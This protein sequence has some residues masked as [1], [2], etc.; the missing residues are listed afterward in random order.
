MPGFI[1]R[2]FGKDS[3]KSCH[4]LGTGPDLWNKGSPDPWYYHSKSSGGG[5]KKWWSRSLPAHIGV[6]LICYLAVYYFIHIIYKFAL[7]DEH[8]E[9]DEEESHVETERKSWS[10]KEEFERIVHFFD[11]NVSPLSKDLTF[12]LGFYVSQIVR[13]WWDQF[14][15]LPNPD[16]LVLL[17]HGLVDFTK[18]ANMVW[19]KRMMR[20]VLLAYV[21]CLRRISKAIRRQFPDYK[22][23][24]TCKLITRK[25]LMQIESQGDPGRVWWIPLS[26]VMTMIRSSKEDKVIAS[27]QKILIDAVSKFQ[28][29]LER[30]DDHDH[31]IL[32]PLYRQVV[33]FAVYIYFGLSLIGNQELDKDPYTFI[34]IFLI[35]KFIFFFGWLEVAEAIASPFGNDDDDFQVCELLSRHVWAV[36]RNL[37]QFRGPPEEE[38]EEE[39]E[40]KHV[41]T[42]SMDLHKNT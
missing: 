10:Q 12:L 5:F 23:L 36:S 2:M 13:R 25:E 39:E 34:P 37:N 3:Q 21:L 7:S 17:S 20:Y 16:N 35:L 31:I 14:K 33:K 18:E 32:P 41:V 8:K 24:V 27:D 11:E 29:S 30:I 15:L 42:L 40:E 19:C 9:R 6:E 22:S 1:H 26:W 4:H 38:E 28:A